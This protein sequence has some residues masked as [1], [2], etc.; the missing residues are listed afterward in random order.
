MNASYILEIPN[1]LEMVIDCWRIAEGSLQEDVSMAY[2]DAEE[3]FLTRMFHGKFAAVLKLASG[4]CFIEAAF[5]RDLKAAFPD[6]GP[7]LK[8]ATGG[9]VADMTL[10]KRNTER[11]TGGDFGLLLIRP[12]V[13]D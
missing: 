12:Q 5:L 1:T 10:H 6:I 7:E 3:E 4:C 11:I 13:T 2:P 9:L 8:Q